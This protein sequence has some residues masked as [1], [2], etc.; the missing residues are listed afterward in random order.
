MIAAQRGTTHF[1]II[2]AGVEIDFEPE[3]FVEAHSETAILAWDTTPTAVISQSN[4]V[5][6]NSTKPLFL[7]LEYA[8]P[9]NPNGVD[10]LIPV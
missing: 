5:T 9:I 7:A 8:E 6:V 1:K 2:S 3:T 4:T 10:H